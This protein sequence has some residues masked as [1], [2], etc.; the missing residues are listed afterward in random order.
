MKN[1]L[2]TVFAVTATILLI[3]LIILGL[4]Y[5]IYNLKLTDLAVVSS[6][7]GEYF[8]A[9]QQIGQPKGAFGIADVRVTLKDINGGILQKFDS[10]IANDGKALD[11][12]NWFVQW[13][14]DFV[15]V[16][17]DGEEQEEE[18]FTINLK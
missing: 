12:T 18:K 5:Y 11:R 1:L 6:D 15:T 8:L 14:E 17:L 10:E 3:G 16:T 4:N 7:N 9:F 2:K 13:S